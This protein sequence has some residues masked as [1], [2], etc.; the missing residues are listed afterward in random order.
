MMPVNGMSK[1]NS[2]KN[3]KERSSTMRNAVGGVP[4]KKIY[5]ANTKSS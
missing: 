5:L 1:S 4:E 3:I 2:T